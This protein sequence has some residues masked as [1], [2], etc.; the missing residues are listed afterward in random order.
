MRTPLLALTLAA[1]L[2]GPAAAGYPDPSCSVP[3]VLLYAEGDLPL[4]A[5]RAAREGPLKIVALGSGTTMGMGASA[6]FSYPT[7]LKE[8]LAPTLNRRLAVVNKGVARQTAA[9]MLKRMNV[10]V[11]AEKPD[12]VIWETGTV[13][14]VRGVE[15]D[16]FAQTLMQ[17]IVRLKE[18]GIDV[19]LVDPQFSR[20][21][22]GMLNLHPFIERMRAIASSENVLVFHRYDIMRHWDDV[23]FV[24]LDDMKPSAELTR[25]IDKT[26]DCI[27]RLLAE[28]IRKE[29][30]E[31][32]KLTAK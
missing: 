3:P 26:Y 22:A 12:L 25:E 4:F 20:R 9:D 27:G 19:I 21:T 11:L 28:L 10:D 18:A 32:A 8:A 30:S 29:L 7:R 17:G 15:L 13:D 16:E 1:G 24:K 2:L 5:K 6:N 31:S 23:G 14:A